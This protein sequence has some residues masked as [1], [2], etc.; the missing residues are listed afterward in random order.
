LAPRR[1]ELQ[2][3]QTA[4]FAEAHGAGASLG[5]F[6]QHVNRLMFKWLNRRSQ[7]RRITWPEY[8]RRVRGRLPRAVLAR[9]NNENNACVCSEK[10]FFEIENQFI[11]GR[12]AIFG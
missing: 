2:I 11:I 6:F 4:I 12:S 5:G 7:K 10:Y 1:K 3:S 8:T 9:K